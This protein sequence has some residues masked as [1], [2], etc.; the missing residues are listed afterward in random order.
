MT[1]EKKIPVFAINL[2]SRIDRFENITLEFLKY[3]EFRLHVVEAIANPNGAVGLWQTIY[4]IIEGAQKRE[5]EFVIIC[6]DDH[7]FTDQFRTDQ[8][9]TIVQKCKSLE[10]DVLLGGVSWSRGVIRSTADLYWVDRF[11]GTQ[12]MI[13]Y[14]DFFKKFL[15]MP[16][17]PDLTVDFAISNVTNHIMVTYPFISI[18]KEFGYSDATHHNNENVGYVDGLFRDSSNK[19]DQLNKVFKIL[20]PRIKNNHAAFR[21]N[22]GFCD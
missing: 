16:I 19:F 11:N 18:Q 10:V 6:E 20:Y 5:E 17:D 2:K 8:F 14:K 13:I 22:P 4:N 7:I 15:A 3:K 9:K 21:K 12:F 1:S